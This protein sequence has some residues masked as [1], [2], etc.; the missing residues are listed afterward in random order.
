MSE[1]KITE[2]EIEEYLIK[3]T[4]DLGCYCIKQSPSVVAGIPDELI[5]TLDGK[6]Y[7]VELKTADGKLSKA[8]LETQQRLIKMHHVVVTLWSI[9]QIDEFVNKYVLYK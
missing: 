7:L 6:H 3:R 9:E 1:E 2:Q 5:L 4:T 8:Q